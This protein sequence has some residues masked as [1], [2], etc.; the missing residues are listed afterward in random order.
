MDVSKDVSSEKTPD[1]ITLQNVNYVHVIHQ[2]FTNVKTYEESVQFLKQYLH[3]KVYD[4]TLQASRKIFYALVVYKFGKEL[5]FSNELQS[6]AR[7]AILFVLQNTIEDKA[8]HDKRKK[9]FREYTVE[10]DKFKTQDIKNYMYELGVQ[11]NQLVEMRER[12][13]DYP[14][15]LESI[16]GLMDKII[17]QVDLVKGE[18]IF[19]QCLE[20]LGGL[21][22]EI[23]KEQLVNAYWDMMLDQL[24]QKK[25][26]MMMKNYLLIKNILLEMREDQDTKEIL[27]EEYIQQLLDKDLFTT[28]TLMSQVDFIFHKMKVYGIP[29][30]DKLLERTKNNLLKEISEKELGPESV[31]LVFKKTLPFLQNYIEIIRIYRNQI[32]KI[33]QEK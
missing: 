1:R 20:T 23:I 7:D 8:F 16:Q 33:K 19:E 24:N 3:Y 29:I 4:Y 25:Y 17:K 30:Y 2:F 5:D 18:K 27:D 22:R 28:N 12:L 14:E 31:V 15:W 11:Y 10:L 21:K 32:D 6:K 26:D 9:I 13:G